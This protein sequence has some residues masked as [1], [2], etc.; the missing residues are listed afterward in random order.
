MIDYVNSLENV[1]ESH[2]GGFFVGWP[3]PPSV[4]GHYEILKN[5]NYIWLALEDGKVVGFIT[6]ISDNVISAY[7][8][9]LEVLPDYQ[10]LGI[11]TVLVKK[12]L[13]SLKQLYMIDLLC[14]EELTA[15]YKRFG[16]YKSQG[17]LIRNFDRQNCGLGK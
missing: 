6:A 4:R 16:M 5:S 7:I 9:L 10:G 3:K 14:D 12:M 13:D 8:P 1:K 17:M 2:L 11:G 15:F